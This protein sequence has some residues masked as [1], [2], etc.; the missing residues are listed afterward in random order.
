M[1][2]LFFN[3][4]LNNVRRDQRR[5]SCLRNSRM[6]STLSS[7]PLAL[8][9]YTDSL[10]ELDNVTFYMMQSTL[11][12]LAFIAEEDLVNLWFW[13]EETQLTNTR[14]L[15]RRSTYKFGHSPSGLQYLTRNRPVLLIVLSN[16]KNC[17][18]FIYETDYASANGQFLTLI[19][20]GYAALVWQ[21]ACICFEQEIIK[22]N[23]H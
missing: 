15:L 3:V 12:F 4:S 20:Y 23:G 6:F 18:P 8:P 10:H 7:F 1:N 17:R 16:L 9:L 11:L 14:Q 5:K 21:E 22:F 13:N 2:A 19:S